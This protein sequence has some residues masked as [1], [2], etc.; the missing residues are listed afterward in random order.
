MSRGEVQCS[1][2]PHLPQLQC[3][4]HW[5][6]LPIE[7]SWALQKRDHCCCGCVALALDSGP[8]QTP[9][10]RHRRGGTSLG[11]GNHLIEPR[12]AAGH[13]IMP[14]HYRQ[15]KEHTQHTKENNTKIEQQKLEETQHLVNT[16]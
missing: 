6:S 7:M 4:G 8:N 12:Q 3:W 16:H 15:V 14:C 1:L 13:D 10:K 5:S 11:R 2:E 9:G